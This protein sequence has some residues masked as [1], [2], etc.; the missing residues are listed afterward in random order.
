MILS[1]DKIRKLAIYMSVTYS[2]LYYIWIIFG[3][4]SHSSL[5]IG[6]VLGI[7]GPLLAILIL[8]YSIKTKKNKVERN[9]WFL[10]LIAFFTYLVAE[11]IWRYYLAFIGTEYSFPG[12]ADLFYIMFVCIY[13]GSLMYKVSASWNGQILNS[14]QLF[15]DA[16][17]FMTVVTTVCWSYIINPIL[18]NNPDQSF[19]LVLSLGYPIALL[20]LLL[21]IVLIFLFSK[22]L[23]SPIVLSLNLVG[24]LMYISGDFIYLYQSIY[25]SYQHF[26][27]LSPIWN[28]CLLFIAISSLY[29]NG[30]EEERLNALKK[31]KSY[32]KTS[33]R[34]II[35]PYLSI[36]IFLILLFIKRDDELTSIIIGGSVVLLLLVIRQSIT[37]KENDQ[38][39]RRVTKKTIELEKIKNDLIE[40][41]KRHKSLMDYHPYAIISMDKQGNILLANRACEKILGYSQQQIIKYQYFDILK[42][43]KADDQLVFYFHSAL[44]GIPKTFET[45]IINGM[46]NIISLNLTYIPSIVNDQ[47]V[48]VFVMGEDVTKKKKTEELILK[49]EKLSVASRLAAGVAHE[50]RNPLTSIKGFLQ[51]MSESSTI[52]NKYMTIV[53]SELKRVELIIYEF[54]NLAKPHQEN[55]FESRNIVATLREITDLLNTNAILEN[56]EIK[57]KVEEDIPLIDCLENQ[58][59]QVFINVIQNAIEATG[60]NGQVFVR[61]EREGENDVS[62]RVIDEGIGIPKER[63]HRLGE[64]FYSTKEKGTGIGLMVC[65]KII[66]QHKGKIRISS[67]KKMGTTIEIIL[68]IIH[69]EE[70]EHVTA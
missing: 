59:K 54:L 40:S 56:I 35:F 19:E 9:F 70:V 10:I 36:V 28:I 68:P 61:V 18:M 15:F 30:S 48:G 12:Y 5:I 57:L 21:G 38:L 14:I 45:T 4:R 51:M 2:I 32:K 67:E 17:I 31:M 23:F 65:Y 60:S 13:A 6:G 62:I 37:L 50:I 8:F 16:F 39:L 20:G 1:F 34:T 47:I 26:S 29:S 11:I 46:G 3:G 66:D 7:F 64:P 41:E 24:L 53:L 69:R 49:S 22:P 25:A 52:N 44:K 42:E 55:S 43:L 27:L 63:L 58:L 33:M